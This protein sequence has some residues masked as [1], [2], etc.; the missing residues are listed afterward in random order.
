[1]DRPQRRKF[2]G[3]KRRRDQQSE[4][5]PRI[6]VS[7]EPR[8]QKR[9]KIDKQDKK[10]IVILEDCPLETAQ[11]SALVRVWGCSLEGQTGTK[12]LR[13]FEMF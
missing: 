5:G 10:L 2:K 4:P 9:L 6:Q 11:M 3:G 7:D 8:Q 13:Y 12:I 1:M